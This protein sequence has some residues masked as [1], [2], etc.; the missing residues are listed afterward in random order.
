MRGRRGPGVVAA[1]AVTALLA[2]LGGAGASPPAVAAVARPMIVIVPG[3]PST[4]AM[5]GVRGY[6]PDELRSAYGLDGTGAQ[7]RLV[8]LVDA[9]DDP[10]AES[11]LAVYRSQFG[12]PPCSAASGCFR[13]LDARGGGRYPRADVAWSREISLDLD[14]LSAACPDC[15]IAL[16]EAD[17]AGIPELGAAVN[18]AAS[19]PQVA[20]IGNSYGV[21]ETPQETQWDVFYHHPGIAITAASGDG[22][23]GTGYPAAS[24]HVTAVGGTTLRRDGSPRGWSESPW[25]GASSGCTRFEPKPPWQ[26]DPGCAHRT[27]ADVSAVADP[28]TGV[29]MYDTY[30]GPGW[31]LAGGTS[32]ATAFIAGVYA[33][34]GNTSAVVGGSYP[35][36]HTD[37]LNPVAGGYTPPAGLGTPAGTGGF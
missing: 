34:A 24:P 1:L 4:P 5:P 23:Y 36:A 25:S 35:Y 19:L 10:S 20:A 2:V 17:G 6:G 32:A 22:G 33:L 37:R 15:R 27:I 7:G 3:R 9:F 16:V 8:A 28:A 21:P 26:H 13:K 18:T 31:V 11:D 29:A 14:M 12:L 30:Q